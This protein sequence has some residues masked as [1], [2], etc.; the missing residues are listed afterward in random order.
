M[1]GR[2]HSIA[3]QL[4]KASQSHLSPRSRRTHMHGPATRTSPLTPCTPT[5]AQIDTEGAELDI[6]RALLPALDTGR[7]LN[8]L[9]EINKGVDGIDGQP[10]W[11]EWR[12]QGACARC[13]VENGGVRAVCVC[14]GGVTRRAFDT[15]FRLASS[16]PPTIARHP[17]WTRADIV[18]TLTAVASKGY[19]VLCAQSGK[20]A[21]WSYS[22]RLKSRAEIAEFVADGWR[23]ANVWIAKDFWH[24]GAD[25]KPLP[26]MAPAVAAAA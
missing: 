9:V 6:L 3:R 26:E 17:P 11:P 12:K 15:E 2:P 23:A 24:E 13:G 25:W 19:T 7:I 18:D 1:R 21:G 4:S 5:H 10:T 22:P 14:G 8:L 20:T 16:N